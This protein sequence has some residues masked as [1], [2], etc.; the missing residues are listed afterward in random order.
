[1]NRNILTCSFLTLALLLCGFSADRLRAEPHK[2]ALKGNE[3]AWRFVNT[4]IDGDDS[5][6]NA[7]NKLK[8]VWT[9]TEGGDMFNPASS[10]WSM[11]THLA[12]NTENAYGDCVVT[13]RWKFQYAGGAIPELIVRALDS[14]RYYAIRFNTQG[15]FLSKESFIMASIWK[16]GADGYTRMLGYR[17]KA[18][19]YRSDRS[20]HKWYEIRVECNGPEIVVFLEDQ[21]VCAVRDDEYP[22]GLIGVGCVY[23]QCGWADL[24]V[25]GKQVKLK[26]AWADVETDLPH[27]FTVAMDPSV[28]KTQTAALA[29]LLPN[30][31]IVVSFQG[32]GKKVF[33]T[34]SRDFGLTWEKPKPGL[35][36]SYVKSLGKM[37]S[38]E[39]HVR[40]GIVFR[41]NGKNFDEYNRRYMWHTLSRSNDGGRTWSKK[42]TLKIPFPSGR[43]YAAIKGKAGSIFYVETSSVKSLTDGSVCFTGM[44][45]NSPDGN[46]TSDQVQ[47]LRSTDGGRTWTANPIDPT[48][49]QRNESAWVE[50]PGGDLL[51]VMRSNYTNSLAISRSKDK[52]KTWSRIRPAGIPFFGSSAPSLLRTTEGVLVLATRGWGLFTSID[53]GRNWSLPTHIRGYTGSGWLANLL[54]MK[55]GRILVINA[56]HGNARNRCRIGAQFV[57]ID[58]KGVVH[59]AP[60]GPMKQVS[61]APRTKPSS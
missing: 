43:A 13:G 14:R 24:A 2:L 18:G 33:T 3:Q 61:Q 47:F 56:T 28:S 48:N 44:W 23:G 29:T 16:G 51:C 55:D 45:R 8:G 57:R 41:D 39:S 7:G 58:K 21:F 35:H 26:T 54:Q 49:W 12:F 20:P 60:P 19:I 25:E 32:D 1:M 50:L 5:H 11:D 4:W 15:N 38:L 46:Y 40:K 17:R 52:G 34:R 42:E 59:P 9:T 27:Q 10:L 53:D 6:F 30:D 37:W 31:E 36:G 22:A